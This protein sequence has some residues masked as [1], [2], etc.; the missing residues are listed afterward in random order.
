MC[1]RT[2]SLLLGPTHFE[3]ANARTARCR[4]RSMQQYWRPYQPKHNPSSNVDSQLFL[5]NLYIVFI[6]CVQ[7]RSKSADRRPRPQS[8]HGNSEMA[9]SRG[10][11]YDWNTFHFYPDIHDT[12][13]RPFVVDRRRHP[14]QGAQYVD[15]EWIRDL[16]YYK[17]LEIERQKQALLD[18]NLSPIRRF[19]S[20]TNMKVTPSSP[21][22][23]VSDGN[24]N[25]HPCESESSGESSDDDQKRWHKSAL[26]V[27][28]TKRKEN[29]IQNDN[30][31]DND[32]ELPAHTS[33]LFSSVRA[34]P[35]VRRREHKRMHSS[36]QSRSDD[37][38]S[39]RK[40][41]RMVQVQSNMNVMKDNREQFEVLMRKRQALEVS[42]ISELLY[43]LDSLISITN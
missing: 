25:V 7:Q 6:S 42:F 12:D 35:S 34:S 38:G 41:G 22:N 43:R 10:R 23:A 33:P 39:S 16:Y 30:D 31:D 37:L 9:N 29:L 14:S 36:A 18:D 5:L 15:E 11:H 17:Q 19:Y 13:S 28:K 26:H 32:D 24:G 4:H 40:Q 3:P 21:S 20:E 1:P 2:F 27:K 8:Y